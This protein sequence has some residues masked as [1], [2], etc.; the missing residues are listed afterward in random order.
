MKF[1]LIKGQ[2]GQQT[3]RKR[4]SK[5]MKEKGG[6]KQR[7]QAAQINLCSQRQIFY[8]AKNKGMGKKEEGVRGRALLN[9]IALSSTQ[10]T[11]SFV[12]L[13]DCPSFCCP[14]SLSNVLLAH[15]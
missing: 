14:L 2:E 7:H 4:E 11:L 1:N 8:G 15:C 9:E 6:K 12:P 13:S 5:R 10:R 3:D